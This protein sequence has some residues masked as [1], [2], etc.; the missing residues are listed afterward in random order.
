MC[1]DNRHKCVIF[2]NKHIILNLIRC[3]KSELAVVF[4]RCV[5]EGF[6]LIE[7]EGLLVAH[8][9]RYKKEAVPTGL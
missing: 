5:F 7:Y 9:L 2:M 6:C 3:N 4:I 8:G 1:Y